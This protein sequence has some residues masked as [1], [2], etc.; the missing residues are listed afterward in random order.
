MF[1]GIIQSVGHLR[2]LERRGGDVRLEIGTGKLDLSDVKGGDSIATNG[3][4]LTVVGQGADWF[5]A[6]VSL[7]TLSLTTLGNLSTGSPL[8]LEK[9]LGVTDRLGGHMVSGHVDGVGEVLS[10]GQDGRSW[11]YTL[12][13][14]DQL[15]RYI[16]RKGSICIDGVSLTVNAVNGAEFELNI[17]PATM[18]ETVFEGYRAGSRVNLEVDLV[19]RYL[20][21][22][23]QGD[24]AAHP[25]NTGGISRAFLASHGFPSS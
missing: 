20:E 8:N 12:R 23:L 15:A 9:S 7:E 11:R 3:V 22:L 10:L 21:R 25:D 4:C 6:D 5:A 2:R 13:A 19:A 18:R 14:P 24:A 16:A 1:T 17:I